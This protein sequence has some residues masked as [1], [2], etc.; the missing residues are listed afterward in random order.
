MVEPKAEMKVDQMAEMMVVMMAV[1]KAD[2]MDEMMVEL[3]AG[4]MVVRWAGK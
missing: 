1:I 3:W 2:K 4:P